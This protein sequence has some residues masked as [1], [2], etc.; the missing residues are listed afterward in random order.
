MGFLS[1]FSKVGFLENYGLTQFFHILIAITQMF[2]TFPSS[3]FDIIIEEKEA[4]LP[5]DFS[6]GIFIGIRIKFILQLETQ[7]VKI[8]G[9]WKN[10]NFYWTIVE[11]VPKHLL[12]VLLLL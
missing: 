3:Q 4:L 8:F 11:D 7:T 2:E 9:E 1:G 12:E 10:S 6:N 5:Q